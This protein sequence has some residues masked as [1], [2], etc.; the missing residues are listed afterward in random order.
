MD[1]DLVQAMRLPDIDE[2]GRVRGNENL[3]SV[4]AQLL[5]QEPLCPAVEVTLRLFYEDRAPAV[6]RD[7]HGCHH[8]ELLNASPH[9]MEID[10]HAFRCSKCNMGEGIAERRVELANIP[11]CRGDKL[12]NGLEGRAI[13][14]AER[15]KDLSQ[16]T[17]IG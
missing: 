14:A 6:G 10:V 7:E 13:T 11:K 12:F 16:V 3:T 15:M 5:E 1:L 9:V 8:K 17:A 4:P 2:G